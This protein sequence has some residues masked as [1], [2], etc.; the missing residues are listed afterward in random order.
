MLWPHITQKYCFL[1]VW[2]EN[3]MFKKGTSTLWP[4]ENLLEIKKLC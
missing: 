3:T 4:S 2:E 1:G